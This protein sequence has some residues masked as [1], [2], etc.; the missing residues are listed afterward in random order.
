MK[1][2]IRMFFRGVRAVV[3]PILLVWE[4]LTVPKGLAR[5]PDAQARVDQE[6]RALSLYQFKTCPYCIRVRQATRRLSLNIDQRDAQHDSTHRAALA[7]GGGQVKVPC[8]RIEQEGA[9]PRWLYESKEIIHYLEQRF[10]D[11]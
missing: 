5:S 6:T 2:I 7:D 9:P 8:L 3:G 10:A 11:R 4:K 1:T